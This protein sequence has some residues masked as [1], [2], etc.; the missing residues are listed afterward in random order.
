MI[1]L[2]LNGRRVPAGLIESMVSKIDQVDSCLCL[3]VE[4]SA[5]LFINGQSKEDDIHL[6]LSNTLSKYQ[7]PDAYFFCTKW[8]INQNGKADR[9]QL[10]E[11]YREDF[12][13]KTFLESIK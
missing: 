3:E 12:Q 13:S 8:P 10:I 7:L 9:N 1:L 4:H 5:V 11:W 6:I 2:K